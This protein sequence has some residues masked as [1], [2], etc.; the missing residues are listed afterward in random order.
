[1]QHMDI[2]AFFSGLRGIK[3]VMHAIT[4]MDLEGIILGEISQT[5][6]DKYYM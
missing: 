5:K 1:M 4:W 6:K 2:I 3:I